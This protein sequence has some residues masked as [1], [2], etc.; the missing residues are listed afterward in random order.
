MEDW[1]LLQHR[2]WESLRQ[3]VLRRLEA[4][5][6]QTFGGLTGAT[7]RWACWV[8]LARFHGETELSLLQGLL[9]GATWTASRAG[10]WHMRPTLTCPYCAA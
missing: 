2:V 9:T 10:K 4:R 6:L 1:A 8:G 7:D 5:Q 3:A